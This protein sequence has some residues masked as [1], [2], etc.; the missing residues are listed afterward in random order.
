MCPCTDYVLHCIYRDLRGHEPLEDLQRQLNI[1][2][3]ERQQ[4]GYLLTTTNNVA[5]SL[6][7][8]AARARKLHFDINALVVAAD[9]KLERASNQIK[10]TLSRQVTC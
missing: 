10:K 6:E 4:L 7:Q 2:G 3:K 1:A 9:D 5:R 8:S